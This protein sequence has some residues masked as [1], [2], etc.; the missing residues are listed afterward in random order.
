M[1]LLQDIRYGL[2]VLRNSPGFAATAVITIG[3]GIGA[4]TAIFSV[5]DAMLWKPVPVPHLESLVTV[6]QRNAE[7]VNDFSS[8]SAADR[9]DIERG[10]TAISEIASWD[11]GL[12]NLAG[13]GGEPERVMQYL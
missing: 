9:D 1:S 8:L 12:A 3:L 10:A 13:K 5:C 11:D 4:T 2:R 7:D 6:M